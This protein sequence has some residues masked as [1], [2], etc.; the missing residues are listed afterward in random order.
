[1]PAV[2]TAGQ[3]V[4]D[5]FADGGVDV[6]PGGLVVPEG[7]VLRIDPGVLKGQ[8]SGPEGAAIADVLINPADVQQAAVFPVGDKGGVDGPGPVIQLL[9][10]REP[11]AQGIRAGQ[12]DLH[13]LGG[14]DVGQQGGR[15]DKVPDQRHLVQQDIAEAQGAEPLHVP[16]QLRHGVR[17]RGL[18][19][20]GPGR[21]LRCH[22][23]HRLTQ[24][25]GFARPPQ[26]VQQ[27]Y[28]VARRAVKVICQLGKAVPPPPPP[29][30]FRQGKQGRA[31]HDTGMEAGVIHDPHRLSDHVGSIAGSGSIYT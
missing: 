20:S 2:L 21:V 30:I 27:T 18:D 19:V 25:G 7:G 16:V 9:M 1:M 29:D 26:A 6:P 17:R 28:P 5:V 22:I 11:K 13:A 12:D 8:F 14:I 23:Q 15:V 3:G 10:E 31:G 4:L 24:Q